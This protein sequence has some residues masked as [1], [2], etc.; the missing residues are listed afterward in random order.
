M[1]ITRDLID[2]NT[3]LAFKGAN[4][5]VCNCSNIWKYTREKSCYCFKQDDDDCL[6]CPFSEEILKWREKHVLIEMIDG[7]KWN[8]EY[9]LGVNK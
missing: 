8:R 7:S 3:C 2:D 9:I 6:Y 5:I 1:N 4:G